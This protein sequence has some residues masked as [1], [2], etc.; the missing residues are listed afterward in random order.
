MRL[1]PLLLLLVVA[2]QPVSEEITN[3]TFREETNK[4]TEQPLNEENL[5]EAKELP[6]LEET[7]PEQSVFEYPPVNLDK[8]KVLV[9]LGKMTGNHVTPIDHM[10]FQDFS[11]DE[12]N[13]EVYSPAAGTV[14]DI[15]H[16][17]GSYSYGDELVEWDDYRLVIDHG[18]GIQS[19][20]I[21]IDELIPEIEAIAP[22][23]YGKVNYEVSAGQ[24]IGYY[25]KNVDYNI[26]DY[27]YE[28]SGFVVPEHYSDEP[29]KIHVPN[30]LDYY[31]LT[32][33]EKL[34]KLSLRDEEPYLGRF[35]HDIPGTL[36]GNWFLEGT[37]DYG[38]LGWDGYWKGHL[39]IS[40]NYLD[41]S[42]YV[43][44]MGDFEGGEV[45]Y[46]IDINPSEITPATGLVKA[47]LF[48]YEFYKD[49][50][51]WDRVGV[52]KDIT[53]EN[54]DRFI[55]TVLIEM[56]D[57]KSVKIELFPDKKASSVDGFVNP[58]VYNR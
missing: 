32:I 14:T 2:C 49:G 11:N 48:Q 52:G 1:V 20:F 35:D 36:Q 10:Y 38:G 9:P 5:E 46:G 54:T 4:D 31:S 55:G 51:R 21:H 45:Q 57:E 6:E 24:I 23:E 53:V 50:E 58:L 22:E 13:I 29:W 30:S 18:C 40:P 16:M 7:C 26:V 37:K 44:S 43:F 17:R 12:A 47:E 56:I 34:K 28:V 42:H 27:N 8:T 25:S 33:Q 19:I 3:E 15:Q 39:S 41:Y